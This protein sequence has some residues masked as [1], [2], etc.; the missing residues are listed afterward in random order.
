MELKGCHSFTHLPR[1]VTHMAGYEINSKHQ[2]QSVQAVGTVT[3]KIS[4]EAFENQEGRRNAVHCSSLSFAET[5]LQPHFKLKSTFIVRPKPQ[6]W[7]RKQL[8][9]QHSNGQ[10]VKQEKW[11]LWIV[12]SKPSKSHCQAAVLCSQTFWGSVSLG[13][14]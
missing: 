4:W 3:L 7:Q 10:G 11:I 14:Q 5:V 6:K 8:A 12:Q 13:K 1:F 9:L 2:G